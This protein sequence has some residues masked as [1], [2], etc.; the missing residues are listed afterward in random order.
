MAARW[1][2]GKDEAGKIVF[3]VAGLGLIDPTGFM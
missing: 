3:L 2:R 1:R